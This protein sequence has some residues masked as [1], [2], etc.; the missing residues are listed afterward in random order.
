MY[1]TVYKIDVFLSMETTG[2]DSAPALRYSKSVPETGPL[3]L[4][5]ES[6]QK[7]V[8]FRQVSVGPWLK[9]FPEKIPEIPCRPF[10]WGSRRISTS[11]TFVC[12]VTC[13]AHPLFHSALG[14]DTK[15]Y[16]T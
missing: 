11:P 12:T 15:N 16:V 2:S 5:R 13:T 3:D 4:V 1:L 7:T 6:A 8:M 14:R 10:F 9:S